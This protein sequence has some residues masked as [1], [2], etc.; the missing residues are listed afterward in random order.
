MAILVLGFVSRHTPGV[1][2]TGDGG[3]E[4]RD[5]LIDLGFREQSC[6]LDEG[7]GALAKSHTAGL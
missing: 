3:G 1:G 7:C 2:R 6:E 4:T 5:I